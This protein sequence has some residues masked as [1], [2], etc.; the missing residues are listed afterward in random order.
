MLVITRRV[1]QSL[2][3][4][5]DIIVKVLGNESGRVRLGVEAPLHVS[6]VREEL[7]AKV[8]Q[9]PLE[10]MPLQPTKSSCLTTLRQIKDKLCACINHKR[11]IGG[12]GC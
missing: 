12:R 4:A 10:K 11:M 6:V 3:I 9:E 5:G 2:F 1:G 7:A 8:R